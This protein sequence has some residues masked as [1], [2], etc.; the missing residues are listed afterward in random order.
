MRST[1][2]DVPLSVTTILRHACGPN[3]DR[4]VTTAMGEGRYR[5]ITYRE[6]GE[7]VGPAGQRAARARHHRRPTSR[8]LH[9]EQRRAPRGVPGRAVHGRGAAH[10]QHP[11]LARADRLHRQRGR[12]PGDHR[13]SLG[14]CAA[15]AGAAAAGDRAHRDRRRRGRPRAAEASGKAVLRYDELLAGAVARL[16][17]ARASTKPHAAAMCYT[18]GTTGNPKG[19]VYSHRSSY[20]HSTMVCTG[21]GMGLNLNDT[22]L[23]DRADVPRQRV[24]RS[25]CRADGGGRPGAAR[26]LPGR[27]VVD[28]PDRDATPDR[29]RRPCRPSGTT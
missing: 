26:P 5:T 14:G 21:N 20:L 3:G 2:Q 28:R 4:T 16:R 19:V 11:A 10:A 7:Q 6:L 23:A 18:S 9:V 13:R 17:L 22:V 12:G 25:V 1:M 8:H 24:G 29:A 15:C 27:P